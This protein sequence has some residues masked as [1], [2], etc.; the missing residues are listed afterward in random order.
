MSKTIIATAAILFAVT[1]YAADTRQQ[2]ISGNQDSDNTLAGSVLT[3]TL[4]TISEPLPA[5]LL[6][7][8]AAPHAAGGRPMDP[9]GRYATNLGRDPACILA[10]FPKSHGSRRWARARIQWRR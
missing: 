3:Q 9:A 6:L 2:F 8:V 7:A 1:A 4:K 10:S 5:D